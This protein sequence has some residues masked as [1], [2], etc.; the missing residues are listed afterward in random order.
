MRSST[1]HR[2]EFA[3][4][5]DAC[6]SEV[7]DALRDLRRHGAV[8]RDD[9]AAEK[10]Q[11]GK[12]ARLVRSSAGIAVFVGPVNDKAGWIA[13]GRSCE[14][15]ALQATALGVRTA[16]LNQPVEVAPCGPP[17]PTSAAWMEG[18]R[19]WWC[20]SAVGRRRRCGARCGRCWS[21]QIPA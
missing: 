21:R 19:I 16:H 18:G 4:A 10:R 2:W 6:G 3:D 1:T 5:R 15:F 8:D 17:S 7:E 14:R 12:Y 13:V 11:N 20:A 9:A